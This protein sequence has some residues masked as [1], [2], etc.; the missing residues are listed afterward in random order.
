MATYRGSS[1]DARWDYH[2]P[3][4]TLKQILDLY[5]AADIEASRRDDEGPQHRWIEILHDKVCPGGIAGTPM[6]APCKCNVICIVQAVDPDTSAPIEPIRAFDS[7]G[8]PMGID[9]AVEM[10]RSAGEYRAWKARRKQRDFL[11]GV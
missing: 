4:R 8:A 3:A 2:G 10:S 11:G 5:M 6:D 9:V 7:Y 1:R